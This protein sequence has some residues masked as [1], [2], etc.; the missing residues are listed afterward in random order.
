[1]L[2]PQGREVLDALSPALAKLPN[3]IAVEG[4]TDNQPIIPGGEYASNWEL[5][6]AR[7]TTVVRYLID[8]EHLG[9]GR[10]SATGFADT[11]PLV[12]NTSP[13]N[14]AINRRVEIV[15]LNLDV[16]SSQTGA[17]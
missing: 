10:L 9:P 15:V 7:A 8:V 1:M 11:R 16:P 3:D 14:Q 4:H 6:T 12:P 13:A 5:S 17:A 2:E